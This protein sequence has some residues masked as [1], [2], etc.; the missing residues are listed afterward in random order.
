MNPKLLDHDAC[1]VNKTVKFTILQ[2]ITDC[3]SM[4]T[5]VNKDGFYDFYCNAGF[6]GDGH[7]VSGPL[8]K[9]E[10]ELSSLFC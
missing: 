2:G 1:D 10:D 4:V 8:E 6:F 7:G 5:C 3:S 9:F